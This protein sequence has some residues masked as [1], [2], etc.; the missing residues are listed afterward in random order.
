VAPFF[1]CC[2][3]KSNFAS[4]SN[5]RTFLN[6]VNKVKDV[7]YKVKVILF[8]FIVTSLQLK[9]IKYECIILFVIQEEIIFSYFCL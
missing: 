4:C 7:M 2:L 8:Y 5:M 1:C 3:R 6:M 9:I